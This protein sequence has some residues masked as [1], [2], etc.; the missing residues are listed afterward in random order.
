MR[1]HPPTALLLVLLAAGFVLRRRIARRL[2]A[3]TGTNVVTVKPDR[4]P[5]GPQGGGAR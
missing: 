3:A 5:R 1:R 4:D 2:T